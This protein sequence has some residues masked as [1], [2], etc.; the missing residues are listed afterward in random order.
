MPVRFTSKQ[1]SSIRM[2]VELTQRARIFGSTHV[3]YNKQVEQFFAITRAAGLEEE[4]TYESIVFFCQW[5]VSGDGSTKQRA[6]TSL[7]KFLSAWGDF[8]LANGIPFAYPGTHLRKRINKFIKG[9]KNRFPH[10]S[11]KTV[12]LC[13]DA[14]AS[15]AAQLGFRSAS[16]LYRRSP[17]ALTRWARIITAHD[18]FLRPVE[19]SRGCRLSDVADHG[20]FVSLLVGSR[21]NECKYKHDPRTCTLPVQVSHLSAGFVL[22][23]LISRVHGSVRR[24]DRDDRILFSSFSGKRADVYQGV[25]E[26][27]KRTAFPQ[28]RRLAAHAGVVVATGR[29]LRAGGATDFFA[30]GAPRWWIMRQGGWNSKAVDKYNQPSLQQ[31]HAVSAVYSKTII[32]A[33][34]AASRSLRH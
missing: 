15:V 2:Q 3:E 12:P 28:L 29:C 20:S 17:R 22:R 18:A 27:W 24:C 16:D 10:E 23:V 25:A 21:E 19:H 11:K 34:V 32:D 13:L 31:R 4:F 14:L 9:L 7:P 30:R 5:Y 26:S 1:V 6:H 8:C 33:A